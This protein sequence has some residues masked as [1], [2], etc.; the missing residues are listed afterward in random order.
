MPTLFPA[1][2]KTTF[3][4]PIAHSRE[5]EASEKELGLGLARGKELVLSC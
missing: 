2:F 5:K 3:S 4:T 1:S